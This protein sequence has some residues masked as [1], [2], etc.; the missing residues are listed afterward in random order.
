MKFTLTLFG[1]H[2]LAKPSPEN[3]QAVVTLA[4]A[5]RDHGFDMVWAGQHYL[6]THFQKFQPIPVL[7][8]VAVHTGDMYLNVTDLLPLNH[9]VR[10]A[11]E[12]ASMDA[13]TNGRIVLTAALG[14]ADHE[15]ASFG[16]PKRERLGR[17]LESVEVIK[18]LWTG[19]DVTFEGR[20]Y[21]LRGVSMNPKPVQKPRPAIWMTADNTKGAI[22]AARHG[23]V[24][25][26]SSH[27]RVAELKELIAVYDE[28]RQGHPVDFHDI[29][30]HRP[31]MRV[32][33]IAPTRQAAL[34]EAR[35]HIEKFWREY[36]GT[37]NQAGEMDSP[38]DFTKP[39]ED[40]WR[41]RF[42]LADP[43]GCVEEIQRYREELGIDCLHFNLSGALEQQLR[44]IELL[45]TKVFPRVR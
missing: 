30:I 19:D 27:N 15:F 1:T 40:L 21:T 10:L 24:W 32:T 26:M 17:F 2:P 7:S 41:D 33:F 20:Y 16:V 28:H 45:S 13:M 38:D 36:Y 12:L 31:L 22:R 8:H 25:L 23:D 6:V 35:P 11:E 4:R 37:M 42:L 29:G 34:E 44:S 14:Y 18:R 39:F 5:A 43:S 9:P 3:L